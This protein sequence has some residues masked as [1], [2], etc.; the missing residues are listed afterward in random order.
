MLDEGAEYDREYSDLAQQWRDQ[1]SKDEVINPGPDPDPPT[2]QVDVAEKVKNR[3]RSRSWDDNEV[4]LAD[5][6][7]TSMKV[8]DKIRTKKTSLLLEDMMPLADE[9][10]RSDVPVRDD[11]VCSST[12]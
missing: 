8:Q 2:I 4:S 5:M 12:V 11:W 1:R 9:S 3:S 10:S 7:E 6:L